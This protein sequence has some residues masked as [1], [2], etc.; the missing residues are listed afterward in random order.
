MS[1][2]FVILVSVLV[3]HFSLI[4][5]VWVN[6]DEDDDDEDGVMMGV[7]V[8]ESYYGNHSN[9]DDGSTCDISSSFCMSG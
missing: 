6:E 2:L 8:E 9:I 4:V 7:V 5:W 1:F 3:L